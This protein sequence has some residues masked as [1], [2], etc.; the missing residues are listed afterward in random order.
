MTR[1]RHDHLTTVEIDLLR[2]CFVKRCRLKEAAALVDVSKRN[3]GK[4]YGYF[5]AEGIEQTERSL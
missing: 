3:A 2:D 1:G 4:Y 5:R